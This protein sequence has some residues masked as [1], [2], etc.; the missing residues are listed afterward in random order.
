MKDHVYS[1]TAPDGSYM[2]VTKNAGNPYTYDLGFIDPEGRLL[3]A[4][5]G[6]SEIT[7]YELSLILKGELPK[8]WIPE[9]KKTFANLFDE[10]IRQA[11]GETKVTKGDYLGHP[12]LDKEHEDSKNNQG[13]APEGDG[14]NKEP[15]YRI[16][17]EANNEVLLGSKVIFP[18]SGTKVTHETDEE[19]AETLLRH[20]LDAMKGVGY[21]EETVFHSVIE[22]ADEFSSYLENKS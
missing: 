1:A 11:A 14:S 7:N 8:E 17:L 2:Y 12:S 4:K 19:D 15:R 9:R 18:N 20:F 6:M 16:T 13:K 5:I 22:L 3:L 21:M 10:I